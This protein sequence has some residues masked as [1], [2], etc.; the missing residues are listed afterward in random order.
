MVRGRSAGVHCSVITYY[1]FSLVI[2]LANYNEEANQKNMLELVFNCS[3]HIPATFVLYIQPE[4]LNVTSYL[5][6]NI[7]P[8]TTLTTTPADRLE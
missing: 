7:T 6:Q 1:H 5:L 4:E 2:R 8:W 3:K